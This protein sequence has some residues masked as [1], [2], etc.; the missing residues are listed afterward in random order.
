MK[1]F[2]VFSL[3]ASLFLIFGMATTGCSQTN[4]DS[5]TSNDSS[6]SNSNDDTST[7]ILAHLVMS[8]H[9]VDHMSMMILI[10]GIHQHVA[11][12]L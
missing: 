10:T 6:I 4:P 7:M 5:A 1:N 12:M 8:I 3:F 2:K 11:I 9:S